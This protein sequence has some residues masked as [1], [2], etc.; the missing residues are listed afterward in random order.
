MIPINKEAWCERYLA[1]FVDNNT[2]DS[3]W[4]LA[5]L[6]EDF[7]FNLEDQPFIIKLFLENVMRNYAN[8]DSVEHNTIVSTIKNLIATQPTGDF[9]FPYFPSR[10]LMQDYTGVPAIVDL[11]AM[12]DAV[13]AQ[14]GNAEK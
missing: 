9:E 5:R 12:R 10:V 6:A 2:T 3:Y 13:A 14:G 8:N 4:S 7:K 11:A 1:Q